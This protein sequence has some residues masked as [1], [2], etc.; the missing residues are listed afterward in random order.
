MVTIGTPTSDPPRR[1]NFDKMKYRD[2]WDALEATPSTEWLPI[3]FDEYA[4]ATRFAATCKVRRHK[5]VGFSD[6]AYY[7]RENI[8]YVK[9]RQQ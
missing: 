4:D 7:Q 1:K 5:K 8:V 9:G 6:L 3:T 2:I